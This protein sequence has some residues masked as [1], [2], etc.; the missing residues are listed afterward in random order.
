VKRNFFVRVVTELRF[1]NPRVGGSI[2]PPGT[3]CLKGLAEMR[4][5]FVSGVW[6]PSGLLGLKVYLGKN[7]T[8]IQ[9]TPNPFFLLWI[10][11]LL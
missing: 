11:T 9:P 1:E 3:M 6:S 2:P 7:C 10:S 5:F 4:G 8:G